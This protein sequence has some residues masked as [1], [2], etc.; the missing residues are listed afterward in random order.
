MNYHEALH[1]LSVND[2]ATEQEVKAAYRELALI[3]HPDKFQGNAQLTKRATE[4][5]KLINQAKEVLLKACV[6]GRLVN[7][8]GSTGRQGSHAHSAPTSAVYSTSRLSQLTVRYN[9]IETARIMMLSYQDAE[10][11]RRKT[12]L[13]LVLV[14][15]CFSIAARKFPFFAIFS[16]SLVVIGVIGVVSSHMQ[17]REISEQ[18]ATMN[19]ER[20]D[21]KRQIDELK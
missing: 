6:D 3:M 17:L 13:I 7:P 20:D 16:G 15:L 11:D 12:N 10:R 1:I 2:G 14:G 21:L 19:A 9:A 8:L 5:F 4:Q 18:L